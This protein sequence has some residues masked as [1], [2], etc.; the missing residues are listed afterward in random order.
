MA[1]SRTPNF[2]KFHTGWNQFTNMFGAGGRTQYWWVN[3][4]ADLA[5][6][7]RLR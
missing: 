1:K 5:R 4:Y 3:A 2:D 7:T 6:R